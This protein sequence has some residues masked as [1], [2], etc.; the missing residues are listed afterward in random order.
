MV[1]QEYYR[2]AKK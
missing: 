1:T 2:V